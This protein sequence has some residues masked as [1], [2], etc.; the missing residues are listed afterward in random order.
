M[1]PDGFT[2]IE[3]MIVVTII[4]VLAVVSV[5]AYKKYSN[6]GRAVEAQAM[7]GEFRAKEEAY[8]AEF[9]TYLSTTTVGEGD[10][11]PVIGTCVSGSVEPCPKPV[12]LG[13]G[14]PAS[15]TTLGINPQRKQLYCGYVALSGPANAWGAPAAGAEGQAAFGNLVPTAPWYYLRAECDNNKRVTA[16]NTTYLTTSSA[17]TLITKHDGD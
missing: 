6:Q 8:R 7:F 3:L 5:G 11:W 4:G 10:L 2:L 13:A 16:T 15:W 9:S 1:R 17:T 14:A 12:N